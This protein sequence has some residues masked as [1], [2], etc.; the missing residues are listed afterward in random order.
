MSGINYRR[1]TWDEYF[2]EILHAVAKRASCSRGR[3][4]CVIQKDNSILA[5]GY[6]GAPRG[7]PSCDDVG[8]FIQEVIGSDDTIEEHCV[9]T[10][11]AEQNAI[12]HA[13]KVG[14]SIDGATLYCTMTP[15]RTCAMLIINSGIKKVMCEKHYHNKIQEQNSVELLKHAGVDIFWLSD[16]VI[17]YE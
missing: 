5:T 11:H 4:G 9:R 15:C 13:A 6:V 1:P 17:W 7:L 16:E 10:V 12:C 8:H 3:S 2:F 14:V